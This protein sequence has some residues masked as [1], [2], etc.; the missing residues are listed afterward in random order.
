MKK[1]QIAMCLFKY[2]HPYFRLFINVFIFC[3]VLALSF[4]VGFS[5]I[6]LMAFVHWAW[7]FGLFLSAPLAFVISQYLFDRIVFW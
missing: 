2:K 7:I 1:H 4:S 6:V 5:P 3:I